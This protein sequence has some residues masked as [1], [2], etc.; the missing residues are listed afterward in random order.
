MVVG[1]PAPLDNLVLFRRDCRERY[2]GLVGCGQL[3]VESTNGKTV[4]EGL[5]AFITYIQTFCASLLPGVLSS[6]NVREM[7][8]TLANISPTSREI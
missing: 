8:Q 6:D 5:S 2:L 7:K 1:D 4:V 3:V